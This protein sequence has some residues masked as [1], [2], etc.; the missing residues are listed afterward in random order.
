M[1][2]SIK[3]LDEFKTMCDKYDNEKNGVETDMKS[4]ENIIEST[5]K[6]ISKILELNIITFHPDQMKTNSRELLVECL[7]SIVTT[8]SYLSPPYGELIY[9]NQKTAIVKC[10]KNDN[11]ESMGLLISGD[12]AYGYIRCRECEQ[13][14]LLEFDKREKEHRLTE[15]EIDKQNELYYY[16][17]REFIR[18]EQPRKLDDIKPT[19]MGDKFFESTCTPKDWDLSKLN[20]DELMKMHSDIH[21]TVKSFSIDTTDGPKKWMINR[22]DFILQEMCSR[23]IQHNSITELDKASNE[24]K[25]SIKLSDLNSVLNGDLILRVPFLSIMGESCKTGHCENVNININWSEFDVDF[26]KL[27]ESELKK[28]LPDGLKDRINIIP[29]KAGN[30]TT[31][32]PIAE[33]SIKFIDV[34]DRIMMSCKQ[35]DLQEKRLEEIK[36]LRES[37]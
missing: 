21:N 25:P 9:D 37:K 18:F 4:V 15:S 10:E 11:L 36:I 12:Y 27:I 20:N 2:D 19:E 31:L 34:K 30:E 23:D 29:D 35:G 33:L 17:I 26:I 13:I 6:I 14:N 32:I 1:S 28:I 3:L 5:K 7:E 22:H 24:C 8:G 16:S